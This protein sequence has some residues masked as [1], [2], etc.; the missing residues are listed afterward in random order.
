MTAND[1]KRA[2]WS[3]AIAIV[4]TVVSVTSGRL[5]P[6]GTAA[7]EIGVAVRTL[8]RWVREG[9]VTPDLTTAGGHHRF[10]VARLRAQLDAL[11]RE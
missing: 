11:T 8:Q 7:R 2:I 6:T 1:T 3:R 5:L 4:P 9:A 10:D